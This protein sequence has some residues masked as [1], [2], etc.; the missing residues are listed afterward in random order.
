MSLLLR[1]FG[2]EKLKRVF[3]IAFPVL[4]Y[5][6]LTLVLAFPFWK[7]G[8][9]SI[10]ADI[11]LGHYYPWKDQVWDGRIAGYPIKNFILF[12]GIFQ[13]VPWRLL[14]VDQIKSGQLPLWN[15]YNFSG[16]PLLANIQNGILYPLNLIFLIFPNLDAWT[17]Y[18]LFQPF[19]A[20]IFA[21]FFLQSLKL[22]TIAC[23]FGGVCYGFCLIMMNHLEFG[24]DGH[25]ALWLPLA[26]S[27]VNNFLDSQKK[28]YLFVLSL[29]LSM[30]ILGG[31]PPPLVFNFLIVF[32]YIFFK[33]RPLISKKTFILVW[34]CLLPILI[35]APQLL[36]TAELMKKT[37]RSKTQ[38]G[39]SGED[40]FLFPP[41]NLLTI[42]APDFFGHYATN[43]SF[44]KIYNSYTASI[45]IVGFV[46]VIYAMFNFFKKK[47]VQF[48]SLLMI[49]PF[50]LM[51]E[52]PFSKMFWSV[53]I[54]LVS[55]VT[56][57]KLIWIISVSFAILA[58]IGIDFFINDLTGQRE[59]NFW[60][61]FT[62]LIIVWEFLFITVVLA[63]VIPNKDYLYV[64]L[65]NLVLPCFFLTATALLMIF[66][67]FLKKFSKML[68]GILLIL[69]CV[70]LVRQGIK[71]NTFIDKEL[72]SP[73]LPIF[74]QIRNSDPLSRVLVTHPEMLPANS[75]I[76]YR[77]QTI[78]GYAS[79]YDYRYGQ[80]I[81]LA[82]NAYP[83]SSLDGYSRTV[84]QTEYGS[85]FIDLFGVKY[86]FSL[87]E[88]KSPKLK[89][90]S[91][92]GK[93]YVY[94][95][96]K[97][98]PRAFLVDKHF[99][100]VNDKKIADRMFLMDK[101]REVVLEK[102]PVLEIK[103][104][105][106]KFNGQVIIENYE[107]NKV[108]LKT[109]SN[110]NSFLILTDS[111]DSGWEAAVDGQATEVLRADFNF[112]AVAV[113][114]GIHQVVFEYKPK[115]F[116]LGIKISIIS[117][118]GIFLGLLLMMCKKLPLF[119]RL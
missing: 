56:P 115:S 114:Q 65:R 59:K 97:V 73:P 76:P 68:I 34:F 71:Y 104:L 18:V 53:R 64:A 117:I 101:R 4:F 3:R 29:A 26:L 72:V 58:G 91:H 50:S 67:V 116:Y 2:A 12:D 90:I 88:L 47:E 28:S 11:L 63:F 118:V 38:F 16:T 36:P 33:V 25:T 61:I 7:K 84:F 46:F 74:D 40:R 31:Y 48:M 95:N 93:S 81:K 109:T 10:P 37:V 24:I 55:F 60:R 49:V 21:C 99:L 14:A 9:V 66:S 70:E 41:E 42:I 92:T 20:G 69:S 39:V 75:N 85:S 35:T 86:I 98:L 54:P 110:N 103:S 44:S 94:E 96:V 105:K 51:V 43:N 107:D 15:P 57:M 82:N 8:L 6:A 106:D 77:I 87:D 112:R 32:G 100:E 19:L 30:T 78:N 1:I 79:L 23:L 13:T 52:S 102:Q 113:P 5:L 119:K 62:P 27:A 111:Y 22:S 17:I 108:T 89:L 45:G 80:F 83:V